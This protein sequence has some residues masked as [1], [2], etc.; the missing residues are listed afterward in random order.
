MDQIRSCSCGGKTCA[1]FPTAIQPI[2]TR[3][4]AS[5][6]ALNVNDATDADLGLFTNPRLVKYRDSSGK[7]SFVFNR[8]TVEGRV[9][10]NENIIANLEVF[11]KL[12]IKV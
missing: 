5:R 7:K 10:T 3:P 12:S 1:G 11:A 6:D 8:T 2:G 9:G 4:S